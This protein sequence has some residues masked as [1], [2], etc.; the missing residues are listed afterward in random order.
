MGD[1]GDMNVEQILSYVRQKGVILIPNGDR[2]N[3]K[4][5]SGVMTPDLAETIRT[6]KQAILSILNQDRV[7]SV[8]HRDFYVNELK[9]GDC[10]QCPAAGYWD[11]MGTGMWCF[12]RGYFLGNPDIRY[13]VKQ[14]S[15][16]VL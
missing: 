3:Y 4:A 11:L 6:H 5:P 14:Q 7:T 1:G 9:P 2:I 13:H 12:H 16:D 10:G 15:M 8:N